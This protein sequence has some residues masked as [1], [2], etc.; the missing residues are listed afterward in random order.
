MRT[1]FD[2]LKFSLLRSCLEIRKPK[3][4]N[5]EFARN[6]SKFAYLLIRFVVFR[7]NSWLKNKK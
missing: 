5:R 3:K 6:N 1:K 7:V 2:F 4:F